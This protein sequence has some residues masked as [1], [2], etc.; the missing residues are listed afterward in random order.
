M[1]RWVRA[2]ADQPGAENVARLR[3]G[4]RVL[5]RYASRLGTAP[6]IGT[7]DWRLVR[8]ATIEDATA[9]ALSG[10]EMTAARYVWRARR[11]CLPGVCRSR[12]M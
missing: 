2:L 7:T 9:R 3:A 6:G 5:V 8:A 4:T 1:D 10:W 12:L 11:R